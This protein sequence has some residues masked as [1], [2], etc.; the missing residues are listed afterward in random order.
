MV[1]LDRPTVDV[2]PQPPAIRPYSSADFQ[3]AVELLAVTGGRHRVRRGVAV[4]VS[5]FAGLV[6]DRSGHPAALATFSR[7]NSET[8]EISA[9]ASAPFD[10]QLVRS[11]ITAVVMNRQPDCRRVYTICS[12]VDFDMQRA[13]QLEGF[14]L[15]A[16]RPGNVEIAARSSTEVVRT[17]G[18][19]PVRDELEYERL[20]VPG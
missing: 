20:F 4:D 18:G 8:L 5:L 13:L 12:N 14:C 16:A 19:L 6:A 15:C 2:S 17:L 3:W 7:P 9:I 11:L 10:E 1:S